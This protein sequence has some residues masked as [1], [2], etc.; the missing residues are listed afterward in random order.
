MLRHFF[1]PSVTKTRVY[2]FDEDEIRPS[3]FV[4]FYMALGFIRLPKREKYEPVFDDLFADVDIVSDLLEPEVEQEVDQKQ[5]A[6]PS[7]RV[8]PLRAWM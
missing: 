3:A 2:V 6:M 5:E 8:I 4:K 7:R 1:R